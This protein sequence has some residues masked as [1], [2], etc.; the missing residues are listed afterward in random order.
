MLEAVERIGV[1]KVGADFPAPTP[2]GYNVFRFERAL[3]PSWP[4]AFQVR[5]DEFDALLFD[6]AARE[7]RAGPA[8]TPR[9]R[10]S[11]SRRTA[12][13][14]PGQS[15]TGNPFAAG[16]ATSSMP[17]D[18]TRCSATSCA[19]SASSTRHQSA[20][21]FAHFR[22][23]ERRPG[24]RR[25]QHQHLPLRARLGVA[26]PAARRHH[27]RRRGLLARLP[28]AAPDRQ[29]R[30]PAA[31]AAVDSRSSWQRMEHAEIAGNLH[32]TGNY[33]YACTRMAGPRWIMAGDSYAFVD[34]IFS[35]GVYLAMHAAEQA[36][37]V[38]DGAL[39]EPAAERA[40][41]ARVPARR[42]SAACAT[43]SWFIYPLHV[44]GD[45]QAVRQPAQR[46]AARAGD[47][48]DAR[49]RRVPRQR[50]A[51][52]PARLQADLLRDG[53]RRP[54]RS[55]RA[56]YLFRRRQARAAFSGGTT[57]QDTA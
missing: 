27:E 18:A 26:D 9:D 25:R 45:A 15:E 12:S 3:D 20:A 29:P 22:G 38:V 41:A 46:P 35:S 49:G 4:H 34:P 51:L 36:A 1:R 24:D 52:A 32:A 16:P 6:N 55:R 47:D 30:V 43:L 53:A 8:G 10:R 39:R 40:A 5:R 42:S 57:G 13:P 2:E 48:L 28:E 31:D 21:L 19:S 7:W 17:R 33:S 11:N 54:A 56:A 37:G 50:R 14:S 44:A 23:V